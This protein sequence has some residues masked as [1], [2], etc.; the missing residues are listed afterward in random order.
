MHL[1]AMKL[2]GNVF[3]LEGTPWDYNNNL[4]PNV[5]TLGGYSVCEVVLPD[6]EGVVTTTPQPAEL[7][8]NRIVQFED[9]ATELDL[10]DGPKLIMKFHPLGAADLQAPVATS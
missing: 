1:V 6:P 3:R 4:R 8:F 2:I 10:Y 9:A 7:H 5:M